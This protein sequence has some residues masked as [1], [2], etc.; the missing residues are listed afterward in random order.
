MKTIE[1]LRQTIR[2]T[3]EGKIDFGETFRQ[4]VKGP[5]SEH[6]LF[7][8]AWF[9]SLN[10]T[11]RVHVTDFVNYIKTYYPATTLFP[12]AI[13]AV[14]SSVRSEA[15]RHHPPKDIDIR[16]LSDTP[17]LSEER[18]EEIVQLR[19]T[20]RGYLEENH[21]PFEEIDFTVKRRMV[22]IDAPKE[23][24]AEYIDYNNNDTSF[25]VAHEDGLPLHI[26]IAGETSFNMEKYLRTEREHNASFVLLFQDKKHVAIV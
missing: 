20:I 2:R 3:H 7:P 15:A 8:E 18:R 4:V 17:P 22:R 21:I 13:T 9:S 19:N 1:R 24:Y 14:G 10:E 5:K 11:D 23:E 6:E 25:E 16:I 26:S 12:T